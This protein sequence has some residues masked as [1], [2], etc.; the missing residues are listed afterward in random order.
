MPT[1]TDLHASNIGKLSGATV[2][3]VDLYR[4][5]VGILGLADQKHL[6]KGDLFWAMNQATFTKLKQELLSINAAGALVT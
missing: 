1:F 6:G 3:G 2:K 4:E 5:L